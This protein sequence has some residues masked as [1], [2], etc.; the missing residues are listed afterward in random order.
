MMEMVYYKIIDSIP[1]DRK[2]NMGRRRLKTPTV[3]KL[4]QR[5]P[6]RALISPVPVEDDSDSGNEQPL[7][8]IF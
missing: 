6:K 5:K 3:G 8:E 4:L 7:L 1:K 2:R